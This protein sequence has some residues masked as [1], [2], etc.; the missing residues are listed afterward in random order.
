MLPETSPEEI[1]KTLDATHAS[2]EQQRAC[3]PAAPP[4]RATVDVMLSSPDAAASPQAAAADIAMLLRAAEQHRKLA[5]LLPADDMRRD[6]LAE[7]DKQEAHAQALMLRGAAGA[8]GTWQDLGAQQLSVGPQQP[9]PPAPGVGSCVGSFVDRNGRVVEFQ[10]GPVVEPAVASAGGAPAPPPGV[11][12]FVDRYGHVVEFHKRPADEPIG[13]GSSELAAS[14]GG[15]P[16]PIGS[17]VSAV[18]RRDSGGL[19]KLVLREGA[20]GVL[21]GRLPPSD[22]EGDERTRLCEGDLVLAING[23]RTSTMSF[24]ELR[25][26]V[27]ECPG[28]LH[29]EVRR[30]PGGVPGGVP[31]RDTA[32][33]GG[34]GMG[35]GTEPDP[36]E[37]VAGGVIHGLESLKK[38][39]R[40]LVDSRESRE[41]L[42]KLRDL[43]DELKEKTKGFFE[44]L[45]G[46]GQGGGAK[47]GGGMGGGGM[48]GGGMGGGGMGGGSMGGRGAAT[49]ADPTG[50]TRYGSHNVDELTAR[51]EAAARAARAV[52]STA[53]APGSLGGVGAVASPLLHSNAAESSLPVPHSAL[54]GPAMQAPPLVAPSSGARAGLFVDRYGNP[55]EFQIR[56]P[57][58][59][60]DPSFFSTSSMGSGGASRVDGAVVGGG[61]VSRVDGAAGMVSTGRM[62]GAGVEVLDE[63]TQLALALSLSEAEFAASAHH[64]PPGVPRP[65]PSAEYLGGL[66]YPASPPP[67]P[68]PPDGSMPPPSMPPPP[69]DCKAALYSM[70][71]PSQ[72]LPFPGVY[73]YGGYGNDPF[74]QASPPPPPMYPP[75][76]GP[77]PPVGM[78]GGAMSEEELLQVAMHLSL[79][80]A[81]AQQAAERAALE[82]ALR[83]SAT[84]TPVGDLLGELGAQPSTIAEDLSTVFAG[85][86]PAPAVEPPNFC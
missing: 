21:I 58:A 73:R 29:L 5:Q 39:F 24:E 83:A 66:A 65:V 51:A 49:G 8:G 79:A 14:A 64:G 30:M 52:A 16:A 46:L 70:T 76:P 50:T 59:P 68:P 40:Q 53:P 82:T 1:L 11:G 23:L 15:A 43:G 36:L 34:G 19:F 61:S 56:P 45:G 75:P 37:A 62:G 20:G 69:L 4:A 55:V 47:G 42:E 28:A 67:P 74:P 32:A 7:A 78:Y 33:G 26:Y 3:G 86:P 12:N 17:T 6:M 27:K 44:H 35:G 31:T 57:A 38:G 63:A 60:A 25:S 48:G 85:R 22:A 54:T 71:P 18:L 84:E 72:P 13:A 2:L 81:E 41:N 10:K 9:P 77:P 80:E